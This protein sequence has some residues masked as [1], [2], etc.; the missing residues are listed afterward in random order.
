M[1]P[2]HPWIEQQ[3]DVD[4]IIKAEKKLFLLRQYH[5]AEKIIK[6]VLSEQ[7]DNYYAMRTLSRIY[8]ER[9]KTAQSDSQRKRYLVQA[10][11]WIEKAL[12]IE[13]DDPQNTIDAARIY[14]LA[15]E[16]AKAKALIEEVRDN[17]GKDID[18]EHLEV[19][20]EVM[21]EF[22]G[23]ADVEE[24]EVLL[25]LGNW[26][27]EE[28]RKNAGYLLAKV[29][30]CL[31]EQTKDLFWA[32][33]NIK[34]ALFKQLDHCFGLRLLA[35]VYRR[36]SQEMAGNNEKERKYL[37]LAQ[38]WVERAL[39]VEDDH[40]LIKETAARIYLAQDNQD[41]LKPLLKR[42]LGID[43]QN[44]LLKEAKERIGKK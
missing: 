3:R 15:G 37:N 36:K 22:T 25:R 18:K 39:K 40:L 42:I 9:A 13:P 20:I 28:E 29:S 32:E 26:V 8:G 14:A 2:G 16:R 44:S 35:E 33:E 7:E 27:P 10:R 34:K 6:E 12:K 30:Q 41:K 43:P 17:K 24:W 1:F 23:R 21:Q 31:T 38:E 4:K 19:G 5:S 11:E